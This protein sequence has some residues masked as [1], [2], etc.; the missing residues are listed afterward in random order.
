MVLP[1]EEKLAESGLFPLRS[2]GIS[3]LQINVGKVCNQS[4][5]HCHVDAGPGRTES[6]SRETLSRCLEAL[7]DSHIP[8]LDITGGAPELNPHFQWLIE[9]AE[10]LC[11]RVIVRTNLTVL[12]DRRYEHMAG[13]YARHKVEVTASLPYYR[14][15]DTDRQRGQGVFDTSIRVIKRLNSIGYGQDSS[16]LTLNLVYNPG[17]AFLPPSQAAAEADFRRELMCR[18]G[19]VFNRL[20]TITNVPVGRF[21]CFLQDSGNLDNYL[22]RLAQAFNPAAAGRVMCREQISV[23]WDGRLY[24]CDFN[25]MLG[26][27][28]SPDVPG[29]IDQF[30]PAV[31]K[32]RPIM[33]DNHCYACTA[34]AGSS[35]TGAIT[36]QKN[37]I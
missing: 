26:I 7:A 31:L 36:G 28:C 17:G 32:N 33:L 13:L 18:Y 37:G 15:K 5:K 9:Q 1:F 23:G 12:D 24:D 34:G 27:P 16:E 35:C 10:R 2:T 8:T 22:Q 20:Y 11:S 21:L 14:E 19:I 29:N 4:C 6:M 3:V 30:D 25:Q